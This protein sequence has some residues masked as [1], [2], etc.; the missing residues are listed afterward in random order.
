[1]NVGLLKKANYLFDQV[2]SISPPTPCTPPPITRKRR[3]LCSLYTINRILFYR[4]PVAVAST[5][6][7]FAWILNNIKIVLITAMTWSCIAPITFNMYC[8]EFLK[9]VS[10][11]QSVRLKYPWNLSGGSRCTNA[12]SSPTITL[13]SVYGFLDYL[14]AHLQ[15]GL[16]PEL[17]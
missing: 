16:D 6:I 14:T 13:C 2:S 5:R 10:G 8:H 9:T 17:C 1:M 7:L 11:I 4:A 3:I 15:F 12:H